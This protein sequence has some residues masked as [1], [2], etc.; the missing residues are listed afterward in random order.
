MKLPNLFALPGKTFAAKIFMVI[1]LLILVLSISFTGFFVHNEW[2][3]RTEI[4]VRQGELLAKF[5]ANSA[6]LGVFAENTDLLNDPIDGVLQ[7][8]EVLLVSVYTLNGKPLKESRKKGDDNPEPGFSLDESKKQQIFSRLRKTGNVLSVSRRTDVLEFWAPVMSGSRYSNDE[9]LFFTDDVFHS[10]ERTIGFVR[11]LLDKRILNNSLRTLLLNS[12]LIALVFLA[13][14]VIVVYFVVKGIT[15]PLNRL[16]ESV[17]S[18]GGGAQVNKVPVETEDEIGKLADAFNTMADSLQSRE[19]EKGQL[20][21]QLRQ[22]HKME[23]IGTLAGGVAHD[24]NNILS[25]IEGYAMLLRDRLRK[26]SPVRDYV[27]QII[28]ASERASDLTRRLLAFSRNQIIN[29]KPLNLNDTIRNISALLVR[30]TGESIDFQIITAKEELIVVAD[31]L[32]VEQILINL[33]ANARDAMPNGGILRIT[34]EIAEIDEDSLEINRELRPGNY[35]RLMVSDTGTGID[36][37]IRERIFDPFFSTKE[38]GKGTGLGLSMAY[39]MARQHNGYIDVES[40]PGRQT[41]FSL[42]LPLIDSIVERR[43]LESKLLP[44]GNRETVLLAEDDRF[45]RMLTKHILTKYGYQVIEAVDGEDA[46]EKLRENLETVQLLLLDVIMPK[47]NGKQVYDE[48]MKIRPDIKAVFMSGYTYDFVSQQGVCSEDVSLISKPLTPGELLVKVHE[49]LNASS[50]D[51]SGA[52][53]GN[54]HLS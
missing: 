36:V 8:D 11:V 46:L 35:A 5:L 48:A 16:T 53:P 25:T 26:K 13:G 1:I 30:L 2:I 29:P 40:E 22:A 47:K 28:A 31:E 32:Q 3:S 44:T 38:V 7:N 21:Q 39:G 41:T 23:A 45:V 43:K 9:A 42:Y 12:T 51:R 54:D 19:A 27:E 34:T 37:S 17:K 50:G 15:K 10:K 49:C 33:V 4:L 6:R 20:E 14:A 18:M 24:F 52:I